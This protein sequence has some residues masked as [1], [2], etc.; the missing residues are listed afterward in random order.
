MARRAHSE[1][2]ARNQRILRHFVSLHQRVFLYSDLGKILKRDGERLDLPP[3]FTTRQLIAVLREDGELRHVE[4]VPDNETYSEIAGRYIWGSPTPYAVA[5]SLRSGAYLSHASAAFVHGL[6]DQ[7]PHT[8]YVNKEQS[9]KPRSDGELSQESIKRA[10]SNKARISNYSFKYEDYRFILLSGKNTNRLEVS[11]VQLDGLAVDV[12]KIE[13]TLIDL[14]VRPSYAG[15]VHQ[16]LQAFIGAK[17]RI[18]IATLLATYK[19]MEFVYPYHQSI[20]FYMSKAGY[21][22]RAIDRINM[23]PKEFDFY[24]DYKIE[25]PKYNSQWRIYYPEAL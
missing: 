5:L 10:F 23:L 12:T 3:S 6:T 20:G 2:Q 19:K 4:I 11:T 8:I 17:D 7:I 9:P 15:G 13:R 21:P 22:Q 24:L 1:I 16:V 25:L 14:T 18:S